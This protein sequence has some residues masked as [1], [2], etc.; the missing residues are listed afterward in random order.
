M[1][2]I[3]RSDNGARSETVR[4]KSHWLTVEQILEC[5]DLT[6]QDMIGST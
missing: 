2:A 4:L 6:V 1:A 3:C 5:D